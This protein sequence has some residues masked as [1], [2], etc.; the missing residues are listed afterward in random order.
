MAIKKYISPDVFPLT[1]RDNFRKLMGHHYVIDAMDGT[2]RWNEDAITLPDLVVP[3]LVIPSVSVV[4]EPRTSDQTAK[5]LNFSKVPSNPTPEDLITGIT[6]D[7]NSGAAT[8][9][10]KVTAPA[11]DSGGNVNYGSLGRFTEDM[12]YVFSNPTDSDFYHDRTFEYTTP[13]VDSYISFSS[14]NYLV[15]PYETAIQTAS[16]TILPNHYNI[17]I[18]ER[19]GDEAEFIFDAS[20]ATLKGTVGIYKRTL[21]VQILNLIKTLSIIHY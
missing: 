13:D 6:I 21:Q 8:L 14:Y 18:V 9:A 2:V 1:I 20:A 3:A 15:E 10:I 7:R 4:L 11:F 12:E 19:S 16:E 5:V 17:S